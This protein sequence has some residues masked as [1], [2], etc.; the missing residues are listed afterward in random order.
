[1]VL[2][3]LKLLVRQLS[4][5]HIGGGSA[6]HRLLILF[7]KLHALHGRVRSLV[8]LAGK[9]L[10]GEDPGPLRCRKGLFIQ[11]IYRRLRKDASAGLLK[12]LL[13]DVLHV[14]A[15]QHPHTR[16]SAYAQIALNLVEEILCLNRIL[17][18]F[19][20]IYSF[21]IAHK[22]SSILYMLIL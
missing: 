6:D 10:H 15:D 4:L 8:K 9:E 7:Y 11:N 13:R 21:Y 19:L 17:R 22:I 16:K 1:M 2:D 12:G 14:V 3:S 18:F 5:D 20:H